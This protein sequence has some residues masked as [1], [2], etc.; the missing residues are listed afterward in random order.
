MLSRASRKDQGHWAKFVILNRK[1]SCLPN[2]S[3]KISLPWRNF[4]KLRINLQLWWSTL[5]MIFQDYCKNKRNC[6]RN[7][8]A[9]M[10][11]KYYQ[12]CSIFMKTGFSI[13]TLSLKIFFFRKIKLNYVTLAL[14]RKCQL[15]PIS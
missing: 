10:E 13:E 3:M 12:Q 4:L 14:Q 9:S 11:S 6:L 2:W 8:F 7:V 15:Q 1:L 5:V